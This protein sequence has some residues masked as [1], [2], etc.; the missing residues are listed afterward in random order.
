MR[1]TGDA[2]E[3]DRV[4]PTPISSS[5]EARDE[6]PTLYADEIPPFTGG[7]DGW[8]PPL[9]TP[10]VVLGEDRGPLIASITISVG[11]DEVKNVGFGGGKSGRRPGPGARLEEADMS[12]GWLSRLDAGDICMGVIVFTESTSVER[13]VDGMRWAVDWASGCAEEWPFV[14]NGDRIVLELS[15]VVNGPCSEFIDS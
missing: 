6:V 15:S 12:I 11:S 14:P 9:L 7:E 10:L 3:L 13:S 8:D 1:L 2:D 5:A 4:L